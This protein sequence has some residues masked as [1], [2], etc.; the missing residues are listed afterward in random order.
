MTQNSFMQI[1][2]L[3]SLV[4]HMEKLQYTLLP[5]LYYILQCHTNIVIH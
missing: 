4:C 5:N 3:K 1:P 2:V